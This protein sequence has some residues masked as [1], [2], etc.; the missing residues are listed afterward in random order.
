MQGVLS[1]LVLLHGLAITPTRLPVKFAVIVQLNV[2]RL[3]AVLVEQLSLILRKLL[4]HQL[5]EQV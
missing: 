1:H 5:K 2:G 3:Q 4:S